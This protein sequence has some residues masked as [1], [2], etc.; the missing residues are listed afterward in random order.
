[1][2]GER[3]HSPPESLMAEGKWISNLNATTPL[4]DAARRVLA[5]RLEVVRDNLGLALREPDKDPEHVH[6][7]RVSTRRAGAAVEIFALCLPDKGYTAA[8]R[9]LPRIRPGAGSARDLDM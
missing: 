1:M 9:Q 7:L 6:Q 8:P 2:S 4:V 5:I 3:Y